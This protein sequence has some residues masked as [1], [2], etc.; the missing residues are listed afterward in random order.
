M[1]EAKK[2]EINLHEAYKPKRGPKAIVDF[3]FLKVNLFE[4]LIVIIIALLLNILIYGLFKGPELFKYSL[5]QIYSTILLNWLLLGIVVFLIM[6]FIR[7]KKGLPKK[8]FE[9]VLSSLASFRITTIIYSVLAAVIIVVFFPAI[10][11]IIQAISVNPGL[12]DSA[13]IFPALTTLNII[14]I[15]LFAALTI[16]MLIYWILMLF[17]FTEIVFEVKGF[18]SKLALMILLVVAV[19]LINML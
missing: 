12:V 8:P 6:Y 2:S 15:I 18:F 7:G 13:T 19:I 1:P 9:K 17:E 10:I 4:S 5:I 3:F 14:G 11:S 16:Y